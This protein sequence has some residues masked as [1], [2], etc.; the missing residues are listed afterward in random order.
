MNRLSSSFLLALLAAIQGFMISIPFSAAYGMR[1]APKSEFAGIAVFGTVLITG[2]ITSTIVFV[3]SAFAAFRYC[4]HFG[5]W[6]KILVAS[7]VGT[8][9]L[10]LAVR[11]FM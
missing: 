9:L 8:V 6:F 10:Y 7:I 4:H 3:V 1:N 5:R 2:V 11:S